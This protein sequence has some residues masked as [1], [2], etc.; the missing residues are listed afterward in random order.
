MIGKHFK[1]SF[2]TTNL[3]FKLMGIRFR[4]NKNFF[5]HIQCYW[6][7]YFNILW[8][9]RD[10]LGEILFVVFG[11][12]SGESFVDLTYMLPCIAM[13]LLGNMKTCLLI[14]YSK[15]VKD[16]IDTLK[17]MSFHDDDMS[18]ERS[19]Y[20]D[21]SNDYVYDRVDYVDG[22]CA[23]NVDETR[24]CV[25]EIFK[26]TLPF[27]YS[28]IKVQKI[29]NVLVVTNFGLNPMFLMVLNYHSTGQFGLFMP[30]HIWYPFNAFN[31][32]IFPFVYIHQVYSA[33]LAAFTVYGPDTLFY[34][35]STF[36]AIQFRLL[37]NNLEAII[38]LNYTSKIEEVNEFNMTIKRIVK[39]H[40]ELI[41]CVQLLEKIFSKST[42]FN[43]ITSSFLICL[44]GFNVTAID[45]VP[46]MLSFI[47]F[48]LVTF[49]QI[50]FFC[51]FGDMIMQS[52]VE[53]AEAVYNS[54]W[55]MV[56]TSLARELMIILIKAQ[57]PCKITA[58]GFADINLRAFMRILST[59]WSY[60]TLLKTMYST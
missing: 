30:F 28:A 7:F 15:E 37:Q 39:W 1:R 13:C 33:Y 46:F 48:L 18:D 50:Y 17:N 8:L 57:I 12:M 11:V 14:I 29:C 34:V 53:V 43:A 55:Y 26:K 25:D 22:T 21:D 45:N 5:D 58:F 56:E 44:T 4:C 38:P 3:F 9:N 19:S 24:D 35:C 54:R 52:S 59:S 51:C 2:Q 47:S 20:V 49:L 31:Y 6:L 10:L 23:A 36:I 60:F 40:L 27:M 32:W 41:R 16:L 42:L